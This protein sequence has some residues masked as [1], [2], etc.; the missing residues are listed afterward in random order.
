ME[1][2]ERSKQCYQRVLEVYPDHERARLF[3]KDADASRDMYY[4]EEA[5]RRQDRLARS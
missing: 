5:R 2:F 1:H 4:D 3:F